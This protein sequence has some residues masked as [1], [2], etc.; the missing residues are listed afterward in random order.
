M[1]EIFLSIIRFP[2]ELEKEEIQGNCKTILQTIHSILLTIEQF[3]DNTEAQK[4][5]FCQAVSEFITE[6]TEAGKQLIKV[7]EH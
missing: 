3:G 6:Y 2:F 5:S 1:R 7:Y 4:L